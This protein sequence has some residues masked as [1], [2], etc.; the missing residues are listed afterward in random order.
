MCVCVCV[1]VC[2]HLRCAKF[3]CEFFFVYTGPE[4]YLEKIKFAPVSYLRPRV[5]KEFGCALE[6]CNR[7]IEETFLWMFDLGYGLPPN[8]YNEAV[9]F[10]NQRW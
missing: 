6:E 10:F 4:Y 7:L 8:D 3:Y 1:C 9:K 5:Y 2:V